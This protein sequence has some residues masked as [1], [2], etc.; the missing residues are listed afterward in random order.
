MKKVSLI[1]FFFFM[2]CGMLFADRGLIPYNP[3]VQVF[4]P[5]QRAMIAWNGE[6]EI[7]LLST[8]LRA[9]EATEVLEVIPLPSEP[10]AKKGDV[11][12]FRKATA[13]INRK[14]A[15]RH[16]YKGTIPLPTDEGPPAGEVTFH[17]KIGA[18]DIS[19]THVLDKSR[20]I[21]WVEEYLRSAGVENPTIPEG[22]KSVVGEYLDEG[23]SWFVFDVVSLDEI[24]KTGEAIQYRFACESLYYPLKI[25]RTAE[26]DTSVELLV[27]TPRLLSNFPALPIGRVKLM[28]EPI[29]ISSRELRGLNAEMD[30]LMGSRED[31]KLRIWQIKGKLSSFDKD[32]IAK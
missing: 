25:S 30:D 24:P 3:N 9:S 20:F 32:L 1:L 12:V 19:V 21:K 31:L 29:A 8:D 6:E 7:L 28:H 10:T 15:E 4:N 18:H 27:L 17:E 5:T 22:T 23:F 14:L 13:L 16:R 26:G 11:E 2:S